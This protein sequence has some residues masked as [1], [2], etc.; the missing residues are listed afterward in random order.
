MKL[1]VRILLGAYYGL[2]LAQITR[3]LFWDYGM[4]SFGPRHGFHS[5]PALVIAYF[6]CAVCMFGLGAIVFPLQRLLLIVAAVLS[7]CLVALTS[8]LLVV[9]LAHVG[10]YFSSLTNPLVAYVSIL[11]PAVATV[12]FLSQLPEADIVIRKTPNQRLERP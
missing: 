9:E 8:T 12:W 10:L 6:V 5:Q 2:G 1:Y 4:L 7:G 11:V 3:G